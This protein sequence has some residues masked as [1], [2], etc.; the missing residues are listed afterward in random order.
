MLPSALRLSR[1][2]ILFTVAWLV[3]VYVYDVVRQHLDQTLSLL[4]AVATFAINGFA[5]WR[6]AKSVGEVNRS[7]HFWM[8]LPLI[9]LVVVPLIVKLVAYL[10]SGGETSWWS[11]VVHLL[12][13]LL[14][15][16]V[17]VVALVWLYFLVGGLPGKNGAAIPARVETG[18]GT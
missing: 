8:A 16:G 5:R 11:Y 17:P 7:F 18:K 14:K 13:F 9:L 10:S 15:L 12:P 4:I 1:S 6:A 2:L 3:A